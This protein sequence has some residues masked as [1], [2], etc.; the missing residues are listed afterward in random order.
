MVLI[1]KSCLLY[2]TA[3]GISKS[4]KKLRTMRSVAKQSG[5]GPQKAFRERYIA[6]DVQSTTR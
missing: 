2:Y 1:K 6:A 5:H 4:N 3:I